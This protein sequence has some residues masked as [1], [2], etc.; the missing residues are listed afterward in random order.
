[1][2]GWPTELVRNLIFARRSA[3]WLRRHRSEYD[4]LHV[5]GSITWEPGD[6]N[7]AHFV[8]SAWLR[9]PVHTVRRDRSLYGL[10]QGGY[11]ALN[12]CWER[13]AFRSARRVVP[14]SE[15]VRRELVR[16]G[17]SPE[18]ASVILNGVDLTEFHPG[19]ADRGALGLPG[20]VPLALFA[21]D[22]K[23]PR[24]N[25]DTVLKALV[26]VVPLHLAVVGSLEGSP[27]PAL[28]ERLGLTDRVHFLGYRRD[29]AALMRASDLF[30]FPS[31]YE[32]CSLVLLEALASGLPV[33]TAITTGG[34]EVVSS[35]AGLILS[36]PDDAAGLVGA[37]TSLADDPTLRRCMGQ[38]ARDVAERHSWTRMAD[39]YLSLYTQVGAARS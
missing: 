18:R 7:A 34:A 1:M 5:N 29:V 16:I 24:K 30:V 19:P 28:A 38:A 17:V 6:V 27:Y 9:S 32:A 35:E 2:A 33:V 10:Y 13:G 31:R 11:T 22:I 4:V 20:S 39:Q 23:T 26:E 21:G 15:S 25:L 3:R 12:A 8:H 36:D 14:V 37:L